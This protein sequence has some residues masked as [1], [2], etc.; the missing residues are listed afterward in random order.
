MQVLNQT[1]KPEYKIPDPQV[2]T[3]DVANRLVNEGAQ[4]IP[5]N[6]KVRIFKMDQQGVQLG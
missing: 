4:L 6:D 1:Y 2:L 3:K 5:V